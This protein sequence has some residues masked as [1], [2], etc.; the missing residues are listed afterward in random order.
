MCWRSFYHRDLNMEFLSL[1]NVWDLV[2]WK[3]MASEV[4][5][6]LYSSLLIKGI[7]RIILNKKG[8]MLKVKLMHE[9]NKVSLICWWIKRGAPGPRIYCYWESV[10]SLIV[11]LEVLCIPWTRQRFPIHIFQL[12]APSSWITNNFVWTFP[13]RA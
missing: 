5:Y 11:L 8:K 7:T 2:I 9:N 4:P 10:S 3:E 6:L 12:I 1:Q 13:V